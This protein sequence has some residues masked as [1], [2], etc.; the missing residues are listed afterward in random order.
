MRSNLKSKI[1]NPKLF[2]SRLTRWFRKNGRDLPWRHTRDPYAVLVSEVML[3]QTQ[4]A[5]VVPF[6]ERWM[7]KF[8]DVASL[9]R[10]NEADVL[11]AWQGLG[12][13]SRARNLR[14]AAQMIAAEHSFQFP[15]RL[16]E[17]LALPGVGRYTAGAVATFAFGQST[18]IVDANIARVLARLL[19]L[20][21]PID[22]RS[23]HDMLWQ[24]AADL[25]PKTEARLFNSALMELGA[26][27]CIP[28]TP[29]CDICPVAEFCQ[30]SQPELLPRKKPRRATVELAE[31]CAFVFSKGQI[32]LE[33]QMQTR[34]RGLWKLPVLSSAPDSEPLLRLDYPF[35][36]HRVRLSVFRLA[37]ERAGLN[38]QWF[39][40][41]ALENVPMPSPHRR[42]LL[43]LSRPSSPE[44]C[45][46]L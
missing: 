27:V 16:E 12:Y 41:R 7:A 1:Q 11:H 43:H 25:Q 23:G 45:A 32:L 13:Y 35:T 36:N 37:P 26:L 31:N 28:R 34:W 42:A 17:I 9:A 20:Q 15:S 14:R 46:G 24:T 40:L 19:D 18:P 33:Q 10:A 4:V 22:S 2:R 21:T 5:T 30:A 38:Q 44:S 39:A 3:Q 6:Y 29:R 8:P